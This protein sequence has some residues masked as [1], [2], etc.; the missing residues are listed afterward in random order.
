[1]V[2]IKMLVDLPLILHFSTKKKE[3]PKEWRWWTMRLFKMFMN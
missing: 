2:T 3:R 1:M